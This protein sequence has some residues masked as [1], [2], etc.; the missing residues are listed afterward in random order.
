MEEVLWE[1]KNQQETLAAFYEKYKKELEN[2]C[3]SI[4]NEQVSVYYLSIL[5]LMCLLIQ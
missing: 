3:N 1:L 5:L 2:V 4:D